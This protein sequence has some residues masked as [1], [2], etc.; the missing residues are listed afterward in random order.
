MTDPDDGDE[1]TQYRITDTF[2]GGSSG[3]FIFIGQV[4]TN[5]AELLIDADE[6]DELFYVGGPV[7]GNEFIEIQASD[8]EL[9]SDSVVAKA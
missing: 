4:Q 3:Y 7:V 8:G 1:V 6:L 2:A 5:G 9:F